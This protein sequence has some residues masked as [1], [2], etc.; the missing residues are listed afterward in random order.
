MGR[1]GRSGLG[2]GAMFFSHQILSRKGPLGVV[3]LAAHLDRK[4]RKQM[5][6]EADLNKS[7][8]ARP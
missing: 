5:V 2:A 7:V 4:L 1:A 6:S 3:W 8:G